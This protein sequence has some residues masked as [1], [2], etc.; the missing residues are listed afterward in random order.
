VRNKLPDS[1]C[2]NA[3]R[4]VLINGASAWRTDDRLSNYD[5]ESRRIMGFCKYLE[6]NKIEEI[7]LWQRHR[8]R[9]LKWPGVRNWYAFKYFEVDE[10]PDNEWVKTI[11]D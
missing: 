9:L 10:D 1:I 7:R 11:L 2:D 6:R 8:E 3:V 4:F 5:P